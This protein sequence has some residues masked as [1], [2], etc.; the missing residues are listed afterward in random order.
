MNRKERVLFYLQQNTDRF[1]AGGFSTLVGFETEEIARALQLDRANVSK[2][3]NELWNAGLVMKVQGRPTLYL[4]LRALEAALPGRF[5]P[6]TLASAGD[7]LELCREA[8]LG[9]TAAAPTAMEL[10]VTDSLLPLVQEAVSVCGYPP[11]GLPLLLVSPSTK[12]VETVVG[13]TFAQIKEK[14]GPDAKLIMVDCRGNLEGG[15]EL[16]RQLFGCAKSASPTGKAVRGCF[17]VSSHGVI[18]LVG[19]HRLSEYILELLLTAVD[20]H[21]FCRMG[22]SVSRPLEATLI[23]S[24][25]PQNNE[26]LL[27]RLNKHIPCLLTI[28][29]LDSRSMDEKLLLLLRLWGEEATALNRSLRLDKDVLAYLLTAGYPAGI[30]EMRGVVRLLC[31]QTLRKSPSDGQRYL[32]IS[33]QVLPQRIVTDAEGQMD[34][35]HHIFRLLALI[36][37]DYLFFPPDGSNEVL[38][39]FHQL[40]LRSGSLDALPDEELFSPDAQRLAHPEEYISQ[41]L[42]HLRQCGS[43]WVGRMWKAIPYYIQQSAARLLSRSPAGESLAGEPLLQLGLLLPM[44]ILALREVHLPLPEEGLPIPDSA[45]ATLCQVLFSLFS[46]GTGFSLSRQEIAFFSAY[47]SAARSRSRKKHTA[48]LILCH[49]QGI[50][51]EYAHMLEIYGPPGLTVSAI[52]VSVGETLVEV[53]DRAIEAVRVLDRGAGVAIAADMPPLLSLAS[54]ISSRTGIPCRG[55]GEVSLSALMELSEQC[56]AG[57]ELS[58]LTCKTP[59]REEPEFPMEQQDPFMHRYLYEVFAPNLTF[60]DLRKASGTLSVA[61]SGILGDL[62]IP[63]SRDVAIKFLSH[64]SYMLERV[65]AGQTMSFPN[66]RRFLSEQQSIVLAVSRRLEPV[67]NTFGVVIPAPEIAYIAEIFLEYQ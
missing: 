61:L 59:A 48:L 16:L 6:I 67:G 1:A 28:P 47:L 63:Y 30:S 65:I 52:D 18:C 11:Y 38:R 55:V 23:L 46:P 24:L 40:W 37:N 36:P 31:S 54:L 9:Q 57:R 13:H 8:A 60:L 42:D 14:R 56:T 51:T 64:S 35:L 3:L 2:L 27:E 49:G 43:S 19:V 15:G 41:L 62:G 66:L 53:A 21:T 34:R 32:A 10:P 26:E 12:D 33:C 44:H 17:E 4:S 22:E 5:V 25:P 45:D 50:A 29:S 58:Q 39:T 20:R 7:L